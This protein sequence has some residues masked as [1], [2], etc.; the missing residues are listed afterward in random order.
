MT[1][2]WLIRVV[3]AV[4][5]ISVLTVLLPD[6]KAGK[7]VKPIL[8]LVLV[9]VV[10]APVFSG[11]GNYGSSAV[12]GFDPTDGAIQYDEK[13][14]SFVFDKKAKNY[15]NN[16]KDILFGY[17]ING[18]TVTIQYSVDKDYSFSVIGVSVNLDGAVINGESENINLLSE[19]KTALAEYLRLDE[20]DVTIN[21]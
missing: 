4:L 20:K 19:I 10:F 6:G 13:Y 15:E 17:G 12:S 5:V 21:E 11:F 7:F 8:S 2:V 14:L 16:C 9:G 1:S 18:A 3:A